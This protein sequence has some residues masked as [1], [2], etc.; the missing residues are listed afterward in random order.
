MNGG[1]LLQSLSFPGYQ[2]NQG[3]TV[4]T[5]TGAVIK[6][7]AIPANPSVNTGVMTATVATLNASHTIITSGPLVDVYWAAGVRYSCTATKAGADVTITGGVGDT[8][9]TDATAVV[10]CS[11][12]SFEVNFD[13]DN[14]LF[15][16][17]MYRNPSTTTAKA[18]AD[19][20]HA[21]SA[22]QIDLR[23]ETANDGIKKGTNV[24]D[25]SAGD[26]HP[27]GSTRITSVRCSHDAITAGTAYVLIGI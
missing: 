15:A 1:Q 3:S 7:C 25:V 19:F 24:F 22:C 8:L 27:F 4:A 13:G 18:S 14:V 16:A 9:P 6:E 10:L 21:T 26:T 2:F 20:W 17:V 11:Q 23:H 12:T 5:I